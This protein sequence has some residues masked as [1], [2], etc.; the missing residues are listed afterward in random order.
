MFPKCY[1]SLL[2]LLLSFYY[3]A[4]LKESRGEREGRWGEW[5]EPWA[6]WEPPSDIPQK[7]GESDVQSFIHLMKTLYAWDAPSPL[8]HKWG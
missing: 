7:T 1:L 2:L 5:E 8:S 6:L 3:K 4:Y